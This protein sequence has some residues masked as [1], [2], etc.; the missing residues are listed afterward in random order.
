MQKTL[1]RWQEIA[2]VA[3]RFEILFVSRASISKNLSQPAANLPTYPQPTTADRTRG[4]Q[5]TWRI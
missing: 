3:N 4:I 2:F 5:L 1:T